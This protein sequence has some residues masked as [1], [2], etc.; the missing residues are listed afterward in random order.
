MHCRAKV[1]KLSDIVTGNP[2]SLKLV[3]HYVRYAVPHSVQK[4]KIPGLFCMPKYQEGT[5]CMYATLYCQPI[6]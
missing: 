6:A 5:T 3:I 1:D 2:V 4:M